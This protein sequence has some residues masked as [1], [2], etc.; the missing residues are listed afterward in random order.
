MI[1][2]IRILHIDDNDYNRLLVKE[3]LLSEP[4]NYEIVQVDSR[5]K[6]EEFLSGDTVDLILSNFDIF[7]YKDLSI[8]KAIKDKQ[9]GVP[10]IIVTGKGSEE[11]AVKAMKLG[12]DDY[13]IKSA[14]H[15]GGIADSVKV[16]LERSKSGDDHKSIKTAL[17]ESKELFRTAFENAAIGVCMVSME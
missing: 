8:I 7:D 11:I 1:P 15:I 3:I 16:V 10:L 9:P 17:D 13:V 14:R 12:A 4:N 2:K 6:L 5:E